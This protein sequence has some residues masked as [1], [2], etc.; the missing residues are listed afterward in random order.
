[1]SNSFDLQHIIPGLAINFLGV[2]SPP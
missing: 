1:M 2:G